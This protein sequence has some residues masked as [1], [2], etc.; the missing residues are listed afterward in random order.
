MRFILLVIWF[1]VVLFAKNILILNSYS[2]QLAWTKGELEG[3][4]HVLKDNK[5]LKKYIE[6]MDTKIFRP[7]PMRMYNY[8]YYLKNKYKNIDFD[9]IITTDD[10]ALNFV[11]KYKDFPLFKKA[12]VFFCG[13][14]NLSLVQK[15]DKKI[16][17]GVFEK[18]EP[19]ENLKFAKKIKK[20]LKYVYIVSDAST[21]GTLVVKQYLDAFKGIKNIKFIVLNKK[22]LNTVLDKLKDYKKNSVMMLLT[23][24]SY[25]LNDKHVNYIVASQMISKI[26]NDPMIVHTDIFVNIPKTNIVG[27]KVTDALSQGEEVGQKVLEYIK[28]TPVEKIPYTFEKANKMYLNVKNLEKFGINAYELG[29]KNAIYVNKPTTFWELYKEWI[30]S[31][32]AVVA[33]IL[34]FLVVLAFK[35]RELR[36]YNQ[37]IKELNQSLEDRVKKAVEEI[38]KKDQL[39][40]HQTRL[41]AMGEMIGAI[42]HQWRQ[43]LNTLAINIQLLPEYV[44]EHGCDEETLEKFVEKNMDTIFFMSST[45]DDFRNFFRDDNKK[46]LFSIKNALED[47]L[48]LINEQLKSKNINVKIK[49][50]DFEIYGSKTQFQQVLLNLIS[51]SKDAIEENKIEEGE[52]LIEIDSKNKKVS[53]TDNGGGIDEKIIYK[54]FEPYFT[55]KDLKGSG[56]GLYMSKTII[57]K[58]FNGKLEATNVKNGAKFT[59][60]FN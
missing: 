15:L 59:I 25:Y 34:V 48:K 23:P 39:L 26:Y 43:P 28:G 22:D 3:V 42:A 14:N 18:K 44:E 5:D 17:T 53:I 11:R 7:T 27:G 56:I 29:Y 6:F 16:Y 35:N 31:F 49:G 54:I 36:N 51:N 55:T 33:V 58:Y 57:E 37:K 10:N 2:I 38:S 20:D 24:S 1:S 9:I 8:Y 13:V 52:I 46:T 19:M 4:L 32:S 41:A 12:K 60:S 45:I 21:S 30:V 50:D 47:T 40:A